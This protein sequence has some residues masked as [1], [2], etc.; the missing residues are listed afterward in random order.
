MDFGDFSVRAFS[1]KSGKTYV[2]E[3]LIG[4]GSFGKVYNCQD[5]DRALVIKIITTGSAKPEVDIMSEM[6]EKL[7]SV[8]PKI[9]D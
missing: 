2:I 6:E 5:G 1:E 9:M 7:P 3:E 4:E 8:Y